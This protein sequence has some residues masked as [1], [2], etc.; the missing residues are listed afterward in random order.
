M[1]SFPHQLQC[2][3]TQFGFHLNLDELGRVVEMDSNDS[4]DTFEQEVEF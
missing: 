3:H 1:E 4:R 2:Q